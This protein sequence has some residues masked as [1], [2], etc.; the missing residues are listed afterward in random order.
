[1]PSIVETQESETASLVRLRLTTHNA[2]LVDARKERYITQAAMATMLGWSQTCLSQIELLRRQ[3]TEDEMIDIACILEKPIDYL[4]PDELLSAVETGVFSKRKV[5]LSGPQVIY[6]TQAMRQALITDGGLD[7]VEDAVDGRLLP[8]RLCEVL[9][10]LAPREQR[11]LAL[12]FGL[13]NE[14]SRT[15]EEVGTE[16][17]VTRE[18]IR[19]IEAKA[20]RKLR[21]PRRSRKLK[22]FLD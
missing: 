11:V 8:E 6:L 12:R 10:T 2:R 22:D 14:G 4:F 18:R 1:M 19:Q 5:E 20:L 17:G 13:E 16:I 21:H 9:G 3:P 15:L 7:A